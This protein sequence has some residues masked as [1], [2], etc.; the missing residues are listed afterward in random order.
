[1]RPAMGNPAT[2]RA[3]AERIDLTAEAWA[4]EVRRLRSAHHAGRDVEDKLL[5][6]VD[7]L[8]GL[9]HLA[10]LYRHCDRFYPDVEESWRDRLPLNW[11]AMVPASASFSSPAAA[12]ADDMLIASG[13]GMHL[14]GRSYG[15]AGG[16]IHIA[17]RSF[18]RG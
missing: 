14:A 9:R 6:A 17:G 15:P 8:A 11:R 18:T 5:R 16:G 10:D 12:C 7:A 13:G 1:M 4:D 2:L 3:V